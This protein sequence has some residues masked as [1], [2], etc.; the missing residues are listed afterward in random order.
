VGGVKAGPHQ[1][2][3]VNN[4]PAITNKRFIYFYL[5]K[6][7]VRQQ[8]LKLYREMMKTLREIPD[9][10]HRE[11]LKTWARDEFKQNKNEKDEVSPYRYIYHTHFIILTLSF[12]L[13]C[14]V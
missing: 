2:L 8:V 9:P 6:F 3:A 4:Q 11:E 5:F 1:P 7:L 12:F 10:Q 14:S 13:F